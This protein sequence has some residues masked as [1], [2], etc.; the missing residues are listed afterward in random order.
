MLKC[1]LWGE[2]LVNM[3]FKKTSLLPPNKRL[4]FPGG[5]EGG[6]RFSETKNVTEMNGAYPC[7]C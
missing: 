4:D 3:Q 1:F 2:G 6:G 5:E 7:F